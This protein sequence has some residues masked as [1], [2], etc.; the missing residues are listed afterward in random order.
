[1]AACRRGCQT[2]L[3]ALALYPSE[4]QFRTLAPPRALVKRRR[5]AARAYAI[6]SAG[7]PGSGGGR[8]GRRD[9]PEEQENTGFLTGGTVRI[10]AVIAR[11]TA[12]LDELRQAGDARAVFHA[13]YL[14]TT[15]AVAD[16]LRDGAFLD[17]D[18]VERWDVA[19]AAF[20][21]DALDAGRRGDPVPRPWAVAFAA[22]A[23]ERS[24]PPL[25]HVLLGMNAHINYDLP[26]A[27]LAVIG[28]DEFGD[29]ALLARREADHRKIDEVLAARVRAEDDELRE[30][31]EQTWQDAVLQPLNRAATRRFLRESRAK[32]WANARTLSRSRRQG[33]GAYAVRLAQLEE[34]SAARVA[35][36]VRP[37]PVLLRLATRGF[38]VRL[39]D[40][41]GP[42][43]AAGRASGPAAART[44][45]AGFVAGPLAAGR[46]AAKRAAA[47]QATTAQA[48]A[49]RAAARRATA[50]PGPLRSFDP[51]LVGRLECALWMAYYRRRWP[52]FL[53]LSVRVVHAAFQLNWTRTLHG[54][55]L[56]LR[57]NQLWAPAENDPE[58]ARRCMRRFYAL[59]RLAHGEPANP[60]R[61]ARLEVEWWRAHRAHQHGETDGDVSPLVAALSRLYS[62]VYGRPA[63]ELRAAALHRARAMDVSDE[64]VGQGCDPASPLVR[65]ERALLVRSYA[66]LLAAVHG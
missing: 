16:A 49:A 1:M 39:A 40:D 42:V 2:S 5:R 27:L 14:R 7:R 25:Q 63:A 35:D 6:R 30:L 31:A 54:A 33:D 10:D 41:Q 48:T 28:D 9:S 52:Q 62:E 61:A 32:V 3:V 65:E 15:Q 11:M 12:Q 21:L 50:G 59:L 26:Q 8:T 24:L 23:G 58:G 56:V 17:A 34:L 20:Y 22:A 44:K 37:G 19:F 64:W 36:L 47:A 29:P 43:A 18:W 53:V 66:E 13:T 38:G 57:A 45:A 60:A 51:V 55:W 46:R 4:C